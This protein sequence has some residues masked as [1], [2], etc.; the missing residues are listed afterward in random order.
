MNNKNQ[1]N[2][3]FEND[4]LFSDQLEA[5]L[6]SEFVYK[7]G[8]INE[9]STWDSVKAVNKS[10]SIEKN[11]SGVNVLMI[12]VLKGKTNTLV[13]NYIK[14]PYI[15]T[16]CLLA[17]LLHRTDD[18][19]FLSREMG[20]YIGVID[21]NIADEYVNITDALSLNSDLIRGFLYN[22]DDPNQNPSL[23]LD[24]DRFS[25]IKDHPFNSFAFI[26]LINCMNYLSNTQDMSNL[27]ELAYNKDYYLFIEKILS[28]IPNNKSSLD[29]WD[30]EK[31][32]ITFLMDESSKSLKPNI[33]H[34][35]LFIVS[36]KDS[37]LS[38][39]RAKGYNINE[40]PQA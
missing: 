10:K 16:R 28:S 8:E 34:S 24:H 27:L 38:N 9:N 4:Y 39:I 19:N 37:F 3:L 5:A 36:D 21:E 30:S 23:N 32:F 35:C 26:N 18:T 15:F 31:G 6:L 12:R 29:I 20:G 33:L 17:Y 2:I 14:Y 13:Y 40:G 11:Q 1:N 25:V 7:G 22:L